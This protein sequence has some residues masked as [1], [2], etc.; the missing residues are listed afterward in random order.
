ML[1]STVKNFCINFNVASEGRT[2]RSGQLVSGH[3]SFDLSKK[4]KITDISMRL[5]G[6]AHIHWSTGGGK[7]RRKRNYSANVT[8]FDLKSVILQENSAIG[9]SVK[10]QAGTHMYPFTCQIPQGDF[11]PS[12]KGV[13]G[14][15]EY[16]LTVS[17]HRPWHMSKDFVTELNLINSINTNQ[18]ELRA[19]LS[20]SNQMTLCCLWCASPAITMTVSVEKKA[21]T[22]GETVKIICEF[23]NGSSRTATPKVKLLQKQTFYTHERVNRRVYDKNLASGFGQPIHAQTCD[24]HTEMMV[25]IPQSASLTISNC[26]ILVVSYSIEV[27]VTVCSGPDLTVLFPIIVC[28]TPVHP[29]PPPYV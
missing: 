24:V 1:E 12:F 17:I 21:F 19:P 23:S 15:I 6:Q 16:M 28:D 2:F 3:V 13:C 4:T 18:P 29:Q 11:P 10:L 22:P 7:K 14:K 9:E 8:Y 5:K 25:L 20:G 26:S 27:S